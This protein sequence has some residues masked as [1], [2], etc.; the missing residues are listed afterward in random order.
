V[1]IKNEKSR[2]KTGSVS[3]NGTP[4]RKSRT[5]SHSDAGCRA[6]SRATSRRTAAAARTRN[7]RMKW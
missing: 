5:L 7:L 1:K 6:S 2:P 4:F 3:P